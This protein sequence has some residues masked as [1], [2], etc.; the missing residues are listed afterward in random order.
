M[1]AHDVL[2]FPCK[3]DIV[4]E[5]H[6]LGVDILFGAD[7][8]AFPDRETAAYYPDSTKAKLHGPVQRWAS[9]PAHF[10][11]ARF[12]AAEQAHTKCP[13]NSICCMTTVSAQMW[14]HEPC[15]QY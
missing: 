13:A 8:N 15:L 14:T 7:Y 11:S 9:D 5:Y 10:V 6:K 2:F 3:R 1:E 12:T 4:E